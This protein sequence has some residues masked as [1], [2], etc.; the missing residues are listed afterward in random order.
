MQ[1]ALVQ[2]HPIQTTTPM[3]ILFIAYGLAWPTW[4]VLLGELW[5]SSNLSSWDVI[6]KNVI[7]PIW[8]T[9]GL[10]VI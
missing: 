7:R 6:Y 8:G 10:F 4:N 5:G 9:C 2:S 1:I 3:K